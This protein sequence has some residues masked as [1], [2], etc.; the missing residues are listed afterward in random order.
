[1]IMPVGIISFVYHFHELEEYRVFLRR[2]RYLW[3]LYDVSGPMQEKSKIVH[4]LP[5]DVGTLEMPAGKY[6]FGERRSAVVCMYLGVYG[7]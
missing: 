1:M 2:L 7:I 4:L 6:V 3:S 5:A